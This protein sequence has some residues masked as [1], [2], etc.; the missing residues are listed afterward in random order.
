MEVELAQLKEPAILGFG[1]VVKISSEIGK[2]L[3]LNRDKLYYQKLIYEFDGGYV[4][5]IE[6]VL[7]LQ[8][9]MINEAPEPEKSARTIICLL[10]LCSPWRTWR[11]FHRIEVHLE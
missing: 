4:L 5:N 11:R 1:M 6:R 8:T 3:V 2:Y 10:E 7:A 9:T